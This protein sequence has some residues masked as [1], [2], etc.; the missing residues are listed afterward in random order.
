[1]SPDTLATIGLTAVCAGLLLSLRLIRPYGQH[2]RH[3][4]AYLDA[5]EV[6]AAARHYLSAICPPAERAA[7]PAAEDAVPATIPWTRT[8][9]PDTIPDALNTVRTKA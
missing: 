6:P 1:M 2:P 3:G 8:E 7:L 5:H 4:A 9:V